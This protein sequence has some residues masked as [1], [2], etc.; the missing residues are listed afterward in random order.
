MTRIG[1][2]VSDDEPRDTSPS[3]R[4]PWRS[5]YVFI[6]PSEPIEAVLI[7]IV[8]DIRALAPDRASWFFIR[9]S[10]DGYHL[11][12]RVRD[13]DD[14][15]FAA[16]VDRTRERAAAR[17]GRAV[18]LT[19][20][21]YEP[22][23]QRYGGSIAILENEALFELSS[24][25]ALRI[26]AASASQPARRI[27]HAVE[28]MLAVPVALELTPAGAATF[29][30]QY[31]ASWLT[32]FEADAAD[33]GDSDLVLPPETLRRRLAALAAPGDAPATPGTLW[34]RAL[35]RSVVKF[36][37]LA[38]QGELVSPFDGAQVENA[39]RLTATLGSMLTSQLHMLNNRLGLS[40]IQEYHLSC[41]MR[42]A[43]YR[44]DPVA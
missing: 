37:G 8:E 35:E 38:A 16:L 14:A 34:S 30:G 4:S 36:R 9:Y 1:L 17:L 40:P 25:L 19:L 15:A 21:N 10:E 20:T 43:F 7:D 22:E 18:R 41:S 26:I 27:N 33:F 28:L 13:F 3:R 12:V 6:E 39:T 31:S 29:F 2:D 11:R 32:T 44:G 42:D 23:V 24:E 5:C